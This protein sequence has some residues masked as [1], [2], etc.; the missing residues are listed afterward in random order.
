MTVDETFYYKT[1][2]RATRKQPASDSSFY[3]IP[4]PFL[5]SQTQVM[6]GAGKAV[7]CCVGEHSRRGILDEK[8]DTTSK[9]P[10]QRK[11]ENLGAAFTKYG[12]LAAF[13]ILVALMVRFIIKIITSDAGASTYINL[14]CQDFTLAITIIIVAVPE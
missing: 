10:L 3:D 14:F 11:L 8:L 6:T 2:N 4:D 13:G 12:I 9:T 7:V 1:E 5:L